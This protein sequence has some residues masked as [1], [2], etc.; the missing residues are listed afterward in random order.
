MRNNDKLSTAPAKETVL[1]RHTKLS[2]VNK[3]LLRTVSNLMEGVR[4]VLGCAA[5]GIICII[6]GNMHKNY[7]QQLWAVRWSTRY[8]T[9]ENT[10]HRWPWLELLFAY[11][12]NK[13]RRRFDYQP[14]KITH[15]L[16]N[17]RD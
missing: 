2:S 7:T 9:T 8:D 6:V 16:N 15:D 4:K 1:C 5:M 14:D 11:H 10:I 3:Y 17:Y 13:G 12:D